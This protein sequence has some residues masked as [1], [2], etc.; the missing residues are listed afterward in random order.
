MRFNENRMR[1]LSLVAA[2]VWLGSGA[3]PGLAAETAVNQAADSGPRAPIADLAEGAKVQQSLEEFIRA[4]ELGNISMIRSRLDPSMI[5]YQRFID[6]VAQDGNRLKMIRIH[7][8]NT[9][10]LAGPDVAVIQTDW[11]KRFLSATGFVPGIYAGHS[12]FL[13]HRDK[14]GWRIAAF[15]GDDLFASQSGTL[16]QLNITP[17]GGPLAPI[18][19]LEVIDPDM[20]GSGVLNVQLTTATGT[21]PVTLTETTPGR[22]SR[23]W[24]A[25]SGSVTLRY[26]DTNPG[27]GRPPSMLMRSAILP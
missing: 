1:A 19:N 11:E 12:T 3:N 13:F 15:G 16:A 23:L 9:Q 18:A 8:R 20:A 4:Y 27:G 6:G 7:L 24:P 21:V 26:L 14:S 22:F 25:A 5:G 17:A 10:V 2:L